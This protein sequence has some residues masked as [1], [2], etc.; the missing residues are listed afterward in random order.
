MPDLIPPPLALYVHLP[1]CVR[2]CPYCDFNSHAA[3]GALP[4]DDYVDALIR[5]LDADLPLVWGRVV[6]SVFFGGGTPS[7]FPPEAID[8]FLQAAAARLRFAPN[9]EITLE[10]NPGT[11]EHGRFD[12]YRAAGVNRLSFG[13]QSFDDAALQRLGRIHDSAEAERA[14]KLAQDAGYDNFNID[15]MYALPEQTLAQAEHDLERAFALQPTHLSHYQLTLEPN[16]VFFARPPQGI[17]DDDDAWDMQ[18]HCQR[19]L[20]AA[21]YA[22]YEV[23]AYARPGRQ[24]AHNLNY[25]RF[26]D[27]L[28]IG[29]GAHGKISSGAEQQVLRRWK[30]KH[31]QSYLASAGSAAAI[32]GDEHV[33]AARLPFEYM[34]NLLRLHEG[35]RLSDF[36]ACTGLPAQVLQTPLARAMAQGWL[37]EQHGRIVPTELG[38]RFT[39]DVVELFLP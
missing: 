3:K 14:I 18:E 8:R 20:A 21:G 11:A 4:F 1:W 38:R 17:P 27:Y 22:Q 7:L 30:H 31:P 5:D 39:N 19:L 12:G 35:F 23:S 15:L 32:G 9:L 25:W 2:K 24:C 28:G 16:T 29:A 10:T 6:H 26:G 13:V 33:P 34:L 36:E 37:V